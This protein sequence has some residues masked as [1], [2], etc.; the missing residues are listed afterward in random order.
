VRL[1]ELLHWLSSN[2]AILTIL[3]AVVAFIWSAWQF[4]DQ[5]RRESNERQ[6]QTFHNLIKQLVEP[7]TPDQPMSLDRQAAVVFELRHFPRYF[8][9]SERMLKHLRK[10]W[11]EPRYARLIE[12][13]DLTLERMHKRGG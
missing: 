1:V 13:I 9:L 12:E 4:L 8:E 7:D 6:F 3:G 2:A 11:D 10:A 5:R